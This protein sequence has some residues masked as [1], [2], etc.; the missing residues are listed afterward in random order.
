MKK[1]SNRIFMLILNL[2]LLLHI[3]RGPELS[4]IIGGCVPYILY[5]GMM[6][7]YV[8]FLLSRLL[9]ILKKNGDR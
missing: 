6:I 4:F 7:L 9:N 1:S 5:Y 2:M 8:I 3:L